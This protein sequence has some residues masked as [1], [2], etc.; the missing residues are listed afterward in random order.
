VSD[1][2]PGSLCVACGLCCNGTLFPHAPLEP[3]DHEGAETIGLT[4]TSYFGRAGFSLPCARLDGARCTV[5]EARPL[6]CRRYSCATLIALAEGEI[7]R[8]EAER[9]VTLAQLAARNARAALAP[10]QTLDDARMRAQ[11]S[12]PLLALDR[13]LDR[14]FR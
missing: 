6:V 3:E 7:A 5:Y 13:I 14:Y 2:D 8:T 4:P 1:S 12:T 10:G 9:R 11:R